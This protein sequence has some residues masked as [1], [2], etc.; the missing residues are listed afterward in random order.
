MQ[1]LPREDIH[2]FQGDLKSLHEDQYTQL[3]GSIERH[4]FFAPV[5]LWEGR[6]LDG[7]QRLHVLD[8]EG[9]EVEGGIPVVSIVAEDEHDAAEKLLLLSSTYGKIDSQGLYEFTEAH[10][11]RM[12]DFDLADL[13][14]LDLDAFKAEFYEETPEEPP[15]PEEPPEDPVSRLGDLWIMGEHRLL[16]GDSTS[17]EA[18]GCL[19]GEDRAHL[20]LTSPPYAV[21]K[22]YEADISYGQHLALL[23]GIADRGLEVIVPGGFFFVNFDEIAAQSHAGPLTGSNR[24]CIYLTSLDYWQIFHTERRYDLY[25]QRIWYKPFNRLQQPFWTYHTSI[26]HHQEWE[27]VWTWRLPGGD[28]DAVH[29]WDI[30]SRAVWDTRNE[31][32]D[33][34]PLTRHVAAF[35]VCLPERAIKAHSDKGDLV[36][37]PFSGSGTTLLVCEQLQRICRAVELFPPYV[38]VAVLRWQA[39]TGK[40]AILDGTGQTFAELTAERSEALVAA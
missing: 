13:P 4:G 24:Q 34:K 16:C 18:S 27:H 31:A 5:F 6:V 26:P 10:E 30:S 37:E 33:D 17:E 7:H 22:E 35:P 20:G 25:A 14:G 38:D 40:E 36:W 1:R 39:Y 32:T 23:G 11:I 12:D 9:W 15:D 21:G 3:K 29:D 19:M 2:F 28:G 8:K